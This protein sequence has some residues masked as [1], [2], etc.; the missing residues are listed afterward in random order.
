MAVMGRHPKPVT[1]SEVSSLFEQILPSQ[2][3][4][5]TDGLGRGYIERSFPRNMKNSQSQLEVPVR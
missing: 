2:L 5:F 3:V 4:I 1:I